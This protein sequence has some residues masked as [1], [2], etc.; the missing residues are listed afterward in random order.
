M[1]TRFDAP[2]RHR[3][4][5]AIYPHHQG[6]PDH[7]HMFALHGIQYHNQPSNRKRLLKGNVREVD[8]GPR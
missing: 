7:V 8:Q 6:S 4:P 2:L 1:S 5:I 3:Y